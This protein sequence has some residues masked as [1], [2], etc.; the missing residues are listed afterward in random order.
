MLIFLT[1]V[2]MTAKAYIELALSQGMFCMLYIYYFH[3][4]TS[5]QN[6]LNLFVFA[7]SGSHRVPWVEKGPVYL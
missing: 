5:I 7:A 2:M 4:Q 1:Y 6:Y 3:F